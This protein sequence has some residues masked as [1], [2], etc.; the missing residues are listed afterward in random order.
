MSN[1]KF[2]PVEIH[3][4]SVTGKWVVVRTDYTLLIAALPTKELAEEFVAHFNR[5]F[6][7]PEEIVLGMVP[8]D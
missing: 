7:Y 2:I 5:A 1:P 6:E 4:D 3:Q 8:K